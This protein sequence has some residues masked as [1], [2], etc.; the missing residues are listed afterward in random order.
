MISA[1]IFTPWVESEI[2]KLGGL[3]GCLGQGRNAPCAVTSTSLLTQKSGSIPAPSTKLDRSITPST[4]TGSAETACPRVVSALNTE[5]M[6][7]NARESLDVPKGRND[8][9]TGH[10]SWGC[11]G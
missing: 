7:E 4:L 1:K 8:L 10:D 3:T 6:G 9:C 2:A 5:L 11:N